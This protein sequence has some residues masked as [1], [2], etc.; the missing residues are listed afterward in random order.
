M[1]GLIQIKRVVRRDHFLNCARRQVAV[2]RCLMKD[3]LRLQVQTECVYLALLRE[4]V[5]SRPIV[6]R[7]ASAVSRLGVFVVISRTP[8]TSS[9]FILLTLSGPV[10]GIWHS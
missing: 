4:G 8:S 7:G 9:I 2:S 6:L 3:E 1:A 5:L 10:W